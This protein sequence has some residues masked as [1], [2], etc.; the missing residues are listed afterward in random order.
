MSRTGLSDFGEADL[1]LSRRPAPGP[2]SAPGDFR[3]ALALG[4]G[5]LAVEPGIAANQRA[6]EAVLFDLLS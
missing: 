3:Y 6:P 4:Q 5:Q 1:R 2:G